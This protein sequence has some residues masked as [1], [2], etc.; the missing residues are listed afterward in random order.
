MKK[1]TRR[2]AAVSVMTPDTPEANSLLAMFGE[3]V[4]VPNGRRMAELAVDYSHQRELA[5]A[6]PERFD[7]KARRNMQL[8]PQLAELLADAIAELNPEPLEHFAKIIRAVSRQKA[9]RQ[10]AHPFHARAIERASEL[11]WRGE[12]E[13]QS[14]FTEKLGVPVK[15]HD[16]A[17]YER[18]ELKRLGI[19]FEPAKRGRKKGT[20]KRS[21]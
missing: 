16:S 3:A 2:K 6:V 7:W 20:D 10:H 4:S 18:R 1:Q 19:P 8:G 15:E 12:A 14:Q 13:T 21:T 9:E 11:R 17:S 5:L